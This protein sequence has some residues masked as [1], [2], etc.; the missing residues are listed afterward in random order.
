MAISVG[1]WLRAMLVNEVKVGSAKRVNVNVK[2]KKSGGK[3]GWCG[4]ICVNLHS[5]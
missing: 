3:L 1:W 2:V 5:E 4:K